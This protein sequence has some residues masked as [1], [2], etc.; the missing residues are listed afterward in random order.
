MRT[1][2]Y[3]EALNEAL[4]EEM[5]KDGNIVLLGEDIGQYGGVFKVTKNLF[6]EFGAK[7]VVDTPISE[8]G[9][10]GMGLGAAMTGLRPVTELM[11]IDFA[12]VAMDQIVN[13][14]AKMKYMS[15][16]QVNVPMVIRTQEGAGRGN[17]AQHSQ[18]LESMFAQV[19]GLK[20]VS[21]SNPYDAKGML[22]SA[23][24]DE[25]PVLFIENKLLYFTKGEVPE[26]EYTVTLD[27]ASVI[28]NGEDVTIIANSRMVHFAQE[29]A[30]ELK[31]DGISAEVIDLR[32]ISPIDM[33]TILTSVKKTCR[34]VLVHEAH[35]S[36]GWGAELVARIQKEAFDY[37]DTPIERVASED[38][39]FPYS[40][41]LEKEVMPQVQDIVRV[42]KGM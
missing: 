24:R 26:Q 25:A 34:V 11:W 10:I 14:V 41:K 20:V 29:A 32:S 8:N 4:H 17:G 31:Q 15:G 2:T 3:S 35:R 40:L 21:P 33:D 27:K 30:E 19:P 38:V 37:L 39:P 16:G 18:S 7:R 1:I 36:F 23:I 6:E 5:Q 42:V 13:Q 22:K 28:R 12:M 9:F